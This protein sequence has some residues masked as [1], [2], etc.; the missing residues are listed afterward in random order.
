M[1]WHGTSHQFDRFS[2]E[3]IGTGEGA[4]AHGWGLYFAE[5]ESVANVYKRRTTLIDIEN[6][7]FK[8]SEIGHVSR[9]RVASLE[10]RLR[11]VVESL[12][13]HD[14]Y[15]EKIVAEAL[16]KVENAEARGLKVDQDVLAAIDEYGEKLKVDIPSPEKMLDE[17]K[18]LCDQTFVVKALENHAEKTRDWSF[19]I[20]ALPDGATGR[21]L[22]EYLSSFENNGPKGASLFLKDLG[23]DGITYN[24]REDG[25][26]Y[27]VFDDQTIK[28]L[29]RN[30][31]A[32][33]Q[34]ESSRG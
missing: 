28:I 1:A 33:A 24:G 11:K 20:D 13:R 8:D 26:F 22:Y 9:D 16:F 5:N 7:L 18:M 27:V 10:P 15:G 6:E 31:K 19:T 25:R 14:L 32:V 29:E 34:V 23:I 4:Q 12:Y 17:N 3:K 30:E 2:T 21:D